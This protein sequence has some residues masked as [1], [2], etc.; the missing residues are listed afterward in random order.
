[1]LLNA[2]ADF[3]A[4]KSHELLLLYCLQHIPI[5]ILSLHL[6]VLVIVVINGIDGGPLLQALHAW[7]HT[8]GVHFAAVVLPCKKMNLWDLVDSQTVHTLQ[9]CKADMIH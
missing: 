2:Y 4:L 3:D 5:G 1:M 7:V 8:R 9:Y 6:I